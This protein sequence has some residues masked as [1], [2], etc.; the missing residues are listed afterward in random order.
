M[1]VFYFCSFALVSHMTLGVGHVGIIVGTT[2]HFWFGE[3]PLIFEWGLHRF[4]D[5]IFWLVL[6]LHGFGNGICGL[7]LGIHIHKEILI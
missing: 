6:G 1:L 7:V 5:G 3:N 2:S 4:G